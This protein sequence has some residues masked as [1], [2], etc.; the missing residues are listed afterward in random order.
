MPFTFV[1]RVPTKLGRVKITPENGG[2][3]YY[4]VVERADEP[5]VAGTPLSA[6]N[7]NAAQET[8]SYNNATSTNSYKRVYLSPT[9]NDANTGDSTSVPMKTVKAAIRKYA[10]WYKNVDLSLMDGTYTEDIG[11]IATDSCCVVLRTLNSDKDLVTINMA[12]QLELSVPQMRIYN[13]TLNTTA[14]AVRTISV[15]GGT[16]FANNVRVN[17]P[18][19]SSASCINVYNGALAWVYNCV[20]NAG[21]SA[22]IYGNQALRVVAIGCTSERTLAR[23]FYAHAGSVIEYT[24]TL[25]ATQMTYETDDGKCIPVAARAGTRQGTMGSLSGAYRTFDGL[26]LQWG[27]VTITPTAAN[28]SK[29][30]TLTFPVA[31]AETPVVFAL[32]IVSDPHNSS[33]ST[34]RSNVS[35]PKTQVDI[36]L[37]RVNPMA[38]TVIWFAIGKGTVDE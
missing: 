37:T 30:Y 8:I 32:P 17:V 1:D 10:K 38:T 4:A 18:A 22:G 31:Y 7:L 20:L 14:S 15:V 16:L 34:H 3:P 13:I 35:N 2:T 25:T 23:G 33:V 36:Y 21:T 28:A 24:P 9:G 11:T 29:N 26:L 6:A 27:Q 5:A 12:T 19:D